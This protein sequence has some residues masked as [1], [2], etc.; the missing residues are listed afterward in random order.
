MKVSLIERRANHDGWLLLFRGGMTPA[1]IARESRL[2][3][4]T[5]KDGIKAAQRR[6]GSSSASGMLSRYPHLVLIY[7][8]SCKPLAQLTCDDVHHGPFPK[9]S[10]C[11]CAVCAKSGKDHYKLLQR[12]PRTDPK[13]EP[14]LP[15]SI[16]SKILTRKERRA[17]KRVEQLCRAS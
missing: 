6:E 14:R 3:L 4:K 5:V 1:D 2:D 8:A 16:K 15:E 10:A 17:L 9:G 12:D 13:P 7:G 11:C